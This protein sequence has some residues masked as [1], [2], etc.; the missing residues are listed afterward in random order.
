M[1][2]AQVIN[3][4]HGLLVEGL[5]EEGERVLDDSLNGITRPEETQAQAFARSHGQ[6]PRRGAPVSFSRDAKPETPSGPPPMP[7]G[8][9]LAPEG[10]QIRDPTPTRGLDV[11]AAAFGQAPRASKAKPA[12][13]TKKP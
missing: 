1:T 12:R 10:V 9:K 4:A 2:L 11:L 7:E 6:R 8:Y 5:D 13:K 3:A